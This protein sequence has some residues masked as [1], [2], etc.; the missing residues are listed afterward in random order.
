[1]KISCPI[2]IVIG[3]PTSFKCKSSY[4]C[5]CSATSVIFHDKPP[6]STFV[7]RAIQ[8]RIVGGENA[9]AHSWPWIVSLRKFQQHFCGG[10]LLNEEWVLTAAHCLTDTTDITVH[11]GVHQRTSFGSQIRSINR[12]IMHPEYQ[13]APIRVN[14]IALFRLSA[15]VR[16]T[17][18]DIGRACLPRKTDY[19]IVGTEL[20]VIGW[21]RLLHNGPEPEVLRQVRVKRIDND[22]KRCQRT[23]TDKHGQFCAMIDGGGKD[24][25]QG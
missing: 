16:I 10:S 8:G 5:G 9:Q 15:S 19:P 4:R 6:F 12:V 3:P 2:L 13:S 17:M 23:I 21:G 22:D 25:C 18:D 20:A 1:M 11:I 24:S 7:D 14:D